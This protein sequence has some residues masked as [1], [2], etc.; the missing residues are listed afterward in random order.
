M[1]LGTGAG[2]DLEVGEMLSTDPD[3]LH[4]IVFII[5]GNDEKLGGFGTGGLE[6]WQLGGISVVTFHAD[7]PNEVDVIAVSL[8][9]GWDFSGA[10]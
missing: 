9:D 7:F 6:E 2:E 10:A 5:D 4:A 1:I 3:N 8:Q